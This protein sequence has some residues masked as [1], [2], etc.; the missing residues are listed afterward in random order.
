LK[1]LLSK[2]KKVS[3]QHIFLGNGS[4]EAIDLVFRAFCE[5]EKDNVV[6]IDPTYGMYRQLIHI[7][8]ILD[9]TQDSDNCFGCKSHTQAD[10]GTSPSF[11]PIPTSSWRK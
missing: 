2:I 6:A 10:S 11:G 4:D 5:P 1:T 8:R 7:I 9:F 3:P